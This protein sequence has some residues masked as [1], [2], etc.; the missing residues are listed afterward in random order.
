MERKKFLPEGISREDRTKFLNERMRNI[1]PSIC[2][3]R[4][5]LLTQSYQQSEGAPYVLR[6]ALALKHVLENMCIFIDE[7]MYKT[8]C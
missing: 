8:F 7:S 3:D 6:R 5:K 4:A 1:K 2:I